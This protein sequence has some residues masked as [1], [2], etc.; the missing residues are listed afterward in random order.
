MIEKVNQ[1]KRNLIKSIEIYLYLTKYIYINIIMKAVP[2]NDFDGMMSPLPNRVD[3][4]KIT[5]N[6]LKSIK[7]LNKSAES[8]EFK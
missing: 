3:F 7:F 5:N 2:P 1:L 8:Y 4:R 6:I